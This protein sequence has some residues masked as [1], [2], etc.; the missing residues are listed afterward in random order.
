MAYH[1]SE[2]DVCPPSLFIVWG[3]LLL[4]NIDSG[5]L[6]AKDFSI[7]PINDVLFCTPWSAIADLDWLLSISTGLLL[8][9]AI[10]P[11]AWFLLWCSLRPVPKRLPVS[12]IS[13][14]LV[15]MMNIK[16]KTNKQTNKNK[17]KKNNSTNI[18]WQNTREGQKFLATFFFLFTWVHLYKGGSTYIKY[19]PLSFMP[20]NMISVARLV[21]LQ[22]KHKDNAFCS[23][24]VK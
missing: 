17:N 14:P 7:V 12:P 22:Y 6:L 1:Q 11:H 10:F 19:E 3:P 8:F 24:L 15:F 23:L 5:I 21:A 18:K 16:K 4:I 2:K 13:I 9:Y 20:S